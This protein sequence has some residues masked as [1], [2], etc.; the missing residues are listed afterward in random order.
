MSLVRVSYSLTVEFTEPLLGTVPKDRELYENYIIERARKE[1]VEVNDQEEIE[2]VEDLAQRGWTG[3]HKD[4]TGLFLYDYQIRGFFKESGQAT[5]HIHSV[6]NVSTKVD[7]W[8]FVRPRRIYLVRQAKPIK[9]PESVLERPIRAMT[10][11]GPRTSLVRSDCV[12][13]GA[14]LICTLDILSEELSE[15]FL[16][17][18]LEYGAMSGM[19]QWRTGG[20]GRFTYE[21]ELIEDIGTRAKKT[22][23]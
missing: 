21:L 9:E 16:R 15:K 13:P 4:D 3:F 7:R 10:I 6:K 19:G 8:L 20:Y 5:K 1:G 14:R 12:N 2:T 22:K 11:R 18:C 23:K 17:T